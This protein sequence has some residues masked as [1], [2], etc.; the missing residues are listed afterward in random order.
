[1][2][3]FKDPHINQR[4]GHGATRPKA[5]AIGICHNGQRTLLLRSYLGGV[6]RRRK[7]RTRTASARPPLPAKPAACPKEPR[8][9]PAGGPTEVRSGQARVYY[10]AEV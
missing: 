4:C 3:E 6:G 1:M 7:G 5:A 2:S 10:A 8:A 9:R